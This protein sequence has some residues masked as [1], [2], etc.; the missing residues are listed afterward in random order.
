[1]LAKRL[2]GRSIE[3]YLSEHGAS[4]M[5]TAFDDGHTVHYLMIC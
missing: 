2:S 4:V 3:V 1:M 5:R